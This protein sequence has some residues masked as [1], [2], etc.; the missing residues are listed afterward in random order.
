MAVYLATYIREIKRNMA[1]IMESTGKKP[2]SIA[3]KRSKIGSLL[4]CM[5]YN[6]EEA[7]SLFAEIDFSKVKIEGLKK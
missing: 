1:S 2:T 6:L 3:D 7:E 5:K 4:A